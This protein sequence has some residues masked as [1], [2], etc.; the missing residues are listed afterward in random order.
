MS[1]AF[2]TAKPACSTL[3]LVQLAD[4]ADLAEHL[5]AELQAVLDLRGGAHVEQRAHARARPAPSTLTPPTRSA[6]FSL[7]AIQRAARAARRRSGCSA[8]TLAPRAS[9]VRKASAWMRDEQVGLHPPR[10]LHALVQRHEE[11]GV[12]RQHGAHRS[13]MAL[14]RSRSCCA[15]ASTTS[16]SRGPLGPMAPGSSPPW[17]G[18]SATMIRRSIFDCA[19]GRRHDR[20]RQHRQRP[21]ATGRR[22]GAAGDRRRRRR[23]ADS[24]ARR[25]CGR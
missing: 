14:M 17:P 6:A 23:A 13:G 1:G 15:I 21:A 12:A 11:V 20:R 24:G 16:F 22:A 7:S 8:N 9:G 19:S 25:S 2:S 5:A 3:R 18:S 10:L 4:L